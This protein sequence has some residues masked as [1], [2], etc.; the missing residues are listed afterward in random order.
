MKNSNSFP[1]L[2]FYSFFSGKVDALGYITF[3][4]PTKRINNLKISFFGNL[5][6]NKLVLKEKYKDS[7][8]IIER[9]WIFEKIS[10]NTFYGFEKNMI[11]QAYIKINKNH[12]TM[13]YKYKTSYKNL[14]FT[15]NVSDNMHLIETKTLLNKTRVSKLGVLVAES[16]LVY[17]KL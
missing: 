7:Y 5:K 9:E 17:N 15:V 12:L 6:N 13:N 8:Q 11:G 1:K 14:N 16:V 10:N 2:N 3:P 4:Y